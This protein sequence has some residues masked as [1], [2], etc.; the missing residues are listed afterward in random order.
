MS[1]ADFKLFDIDADGEVDLSDAG[2]VAP[3][4]LSP[5]LL[6][7]GRAEGWI[8]ERDGEWVIDWSKA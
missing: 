5:E 6:Q 7:R 8:V 1:P 2:P 3:M 4:V